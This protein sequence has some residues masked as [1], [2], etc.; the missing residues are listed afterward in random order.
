MNSLSYVSDRYDTSAS[1]SPHSGGSDENDTFVDGKQVSTNEDSLIMKNN[2]DFKSVFTNWS[3]S[4]VWLISCDLYMLNRAIV[5][6]NG[7][8]AAWPVFSRAHRQGIGAN[9]TRLPGMLNPV[10]I[11]IKS[12]L[13]F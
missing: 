10:I 2:E 5:N 3:D 8:H 11:A 13:R 7:R 12:R 1:H 9:D 6:A 4:F